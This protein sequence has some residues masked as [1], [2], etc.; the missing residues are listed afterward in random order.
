MTNQASSIGTLARASAAGG[1][2]RCFAAT[3]TEV[4]DEARRRHGLYPT[5]AAAVGRTMTATAI[6]GAMLKDDQRVMIEIVGDGPIG[7]IVAD[8]D[9]HGNV[10]AYATNPQVHLPANAKGKLDVAGAVG[11]GTLHVTKDLRLREMYRGMVP[12]ISGEIAEDFAHYFTQSEQV[13]SAVSL[14]VLVGTTGEIRAAGGLIIQVMPG[15][16]SDLIDEL[17]QRLTALQSVSHMVSLGMT[18][19]QIMDA[20]LHGLDVNRLDTM[21]LKFSCGCSEDRFSRA[22]IALGP[23]ELT[24]MI[25]EQGGAELV[26]N[27]CAEVY[28]FSESDLRELIRTTTTPKADE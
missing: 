5:A 26:C 21:E 9:A 10:R 14:G 12:L 23:A 13:P 7:R 25:N 2:L 18:P 3:T 19:D 22:L 27:F 8:A 24:D 1:Y 28:H 17:E 6:M 16:E 4:V 11:A 20:A 15:A